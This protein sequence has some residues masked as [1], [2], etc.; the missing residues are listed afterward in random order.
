MG[1]DGGPCAFVY[2]R[3][4]HES[5]G[6]HRRGI[7]Y[8]APADRLSGYGLQRLETGQWTVNVDHDGFPRRNQL[9]INGQTVYTFRS[10]Q[11]GKTSPVKTCSRPLDQ[12]S[13][14]ITVPPGPSS[15]TMK[16]KLF[17]GYRPAC[18]GVRRLFCVD[19]DDPL[20]QAIRRGMM[21]GGIVYLISGGRFLSVLV[22][23]WP[24]TSF[25]AQRFATKAVGQ[26]G[27]SAFSSRD[28]MACLR[29]SGHFIGLGS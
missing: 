12:H 16:A 29:P 17:F 7:N 2:L 20:L 22:R 1:R 28:G 27:R 4:R 3:Q 23:Q 13:P 9:D 26:A 24:S 18:R 19:S 6:D 21:H 8:Y 10:K 11:S 5:T 15:M 14:T 25:F